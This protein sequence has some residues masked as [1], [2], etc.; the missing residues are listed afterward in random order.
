MLEKLVFNKRK[1]H[2]VESCH[3]PFVENGF[4]MQLKDSV[5]MKYAIMIGDAPV[6]TRETAPT[7]GTKCG[8]T[9]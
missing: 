9:E 4:A 8:C 6:D 3:E 2:L 5:S 1:Q 7:A